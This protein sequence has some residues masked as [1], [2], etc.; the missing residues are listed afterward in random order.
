MA[1][2]EQGLL[3]Q[4]L[5]WLL[6][7]TKFPAQLRLR[8]AEK[9][10]SHKAFRVV[11]ERGAAYRAE[12]EPTGGEHFK[13]GSLTAQIKALTASGLGKLRLMI[14]PP[15]PPP[16]KI[17]QIQRP[18]GKPL[19]FYRLGTGTSD[20]AHNPTHTQTTNACTCAPIILT[21]H[22]LH[23][24]DTPKHKHITHTHEYTRTRGK[25]LFHTHASPKIHTRTGE[26]RE[27]KDGRCAQ[28]PALRHVHQATLRANRRS[29]LSTH[30][31]QAPSRGPTS[32]N[33]LPGGRHVT[34]R[35]RRT[36][37]PK[38]KGKGIVG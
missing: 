19:L 4:S 35:A 16:T 3:G 31:A 8:L 6:R 22:T 23:A 38:S 36:Q 37:S 5:R 32:P 1:I 30:L 11:G 25:R 12:Y 34:A 29:R 9:R 28:G 18:I 20:N 13:S 14:P 17:F 7:R 21:H 26:E 15:P 27:G 24:E 10:L 2:I 33:A